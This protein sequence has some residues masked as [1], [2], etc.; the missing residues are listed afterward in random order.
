MEF[1]SKTEIKDDRLSVDIETDII[2]LQISEYN[3]VL[4]KVLHSFGNSQSN[5]VNAFN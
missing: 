4:V 3:V 5:V 2:R 1:T